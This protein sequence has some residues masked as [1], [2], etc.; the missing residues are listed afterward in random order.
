MT[1]LPGIDLRQLRIKALNLRVA[2]EERGY[3]V[4]TR[5][6]LGRIEAVGYFCMDH[7][8]DQVC[9]GASE[10][11]ALQSLWTAVSGSTR[12]PDFDGE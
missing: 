7:R 6:A 5:P 2:I 4:S 8:A 10:V 3:L 11:D 9:S 12:P 1:A